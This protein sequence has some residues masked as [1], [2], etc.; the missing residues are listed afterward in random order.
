MSPTFCWKHTV[1]VKHLSDVWPTF[2]WKHTVLVIHLSD[3]WPTFCWKH[4]V[5]EIHL[6]DV[7]PTFCWKHTVLVI[8]FSDVWPTLCRI[9]TVLVIHLSDVWPTFCRIQ[10]VLA[11]HLSDVWP[12]KESFF[13]NINYLPMERN[14][15]I[16]VN[17][18]GKWNNIIVIIIIIIS[19]MLKMVCYNLSTVIS[20]Q[21]GATRQGTLYQDIWRKTQKSN[22]LC[23]GRQKMEEFMYSCKNQVRWWMCLTPKITLSQ[24]KLR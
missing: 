16:K 8:H 1:L 5:L 18:I 17:P 9:H 11:I 10:T 7:W 20:C 6:S 23:I 13:F 14:Q 15:Q 21:L 19:I 3:V 12:T 2:C 22:W 4:T 24:K